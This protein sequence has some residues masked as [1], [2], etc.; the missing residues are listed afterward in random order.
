MPSIARAL[1]ELDTLPYALDL[2]HR[3]VSLVKLQNVTEEAAVTFGLDNDTDRNDI[4]NPQ[5]QLILASFEKRL[6]AWLRD[7]PQDVLDGT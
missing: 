5:T 3:L 4:A 7:V 2:D 1:I 6:E